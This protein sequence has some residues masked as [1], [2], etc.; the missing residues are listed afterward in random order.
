MVFG[1]I[2]LVPLFQKIPINI[3]VKHY[4]KFFKSLLSQIEL[5]GPLVWRS[6]FEWN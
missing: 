3:L 4:L 5:K 1:H 2:K 6:G